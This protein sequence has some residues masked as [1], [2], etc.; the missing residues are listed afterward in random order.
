VDAIVIWADLAQHLTPE[1]LRPAAGSPAVGSANVRILHVHATVQSALSLWPFG[2]GVWVC[3]R[4]TN[5]R[6]RLCANFELADGQQI[7]CFREQGP[8]LS[9]NPGLRSE[10]AQISGTVS[11]ANQKYNALQATVRKRWSAGLEYQVALTYSH[12]M[13]DS[14]GYYGQGGQAGAQSPYWQYLYRQK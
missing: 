8:H 9:G 5:H 4:E 10:I 3:H 13:S 2:R 6:P 7:W 1:V 14:I 12:G 11:V